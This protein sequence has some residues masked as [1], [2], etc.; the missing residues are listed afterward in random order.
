[1]KPI[2]CAICF[3]FVII[4]IFLLP[5]YIL[6]ENKVKKMS[7]SNDTFYV[8]LT[9]NKAFV[10]PIQSGNSASD[11]Y[12]V[13]PNPINLTT[14]YEVALVE[15][16]FTKDWFN[17]RQEELIVLSA[18][19]GDITDQPAMILPPNNYDTIDHLLTDI[20]DV[21]NLNKIYYNL[22]TPPS[23]KVDTRDGKIK[24]MP[25]RCNKQITVPLF[26]QTMSEI[27]G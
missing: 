14:D 6:L 11:F 8:H 7:N 5:A 25:G 19:C 10:S 2:F 13:Y 17:I 26:S 16:T 24:I 1:M 21:I 22:E 15:L 18:E 27:L 4:T 3:C 20:N 23:L 12:N 9:N